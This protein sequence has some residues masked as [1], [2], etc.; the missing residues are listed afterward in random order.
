MASTTTRSLRPTPAPSAAAATLCLRSTCAVARSTTRT[1][2]TSAMTVMTRA[3]LRT[4]PLLIRRQSSAPTAGSSGRRLSLSCCATG[5][6]LRAGRRAFGLVAAPTAT[7]LQMIAPAVGIVRQ[8]E[9]YHLPMRS[10]TRSASA[11]PA[12]QSQEQTAIAL[13]AGSSATAVRT[14]KPKKQEPN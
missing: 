7:S 5:T 9:H 13:A 1:A 12:R 8:K 3:A 11:V 2:A 14:S 6:A 4:A 10:W